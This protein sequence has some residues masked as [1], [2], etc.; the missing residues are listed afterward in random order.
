MINNPCCPIAKGVKLSPI[1]SKQS[2]DKTLFSLPLINALIVK[3]PV[4]AK[5]SKFL[6][7]ILVYLNG[8]QV[9]HKGLNRI[10]FLICVL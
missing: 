6:K 1:S 8:A 3:K 5:F 7:P 4:S 2:L 9:T 10:Y